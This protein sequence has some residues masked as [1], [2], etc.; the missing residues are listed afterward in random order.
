MRDSM[1][2]AFIHGVRDVRVASVPRP[3][4]GDGELLLAVRAVGI[5]GSDLHYYLEGGIGSAAVE[6]PLILGHEFSAEIVDDRA[7]DF[8]LTSGSLVA[9]E[10]ARAC[11]SCEWCIQG[12]PNLCP[13]VHFAGSP[14]DLHGGLAEYVTALPEAI[15]PVPDAIDAAAAALLEP[16]GVAIH[17][18]DLARPR[19]MDSVT[20]LGAGPIGLLILQVARLAGAARL[21]AIDPIPSRTTLAE[22]LG[23]DRTAST[24]EAVLEW[25]DGRGTDLVFE[26]TNSSLAPDQATRAARIGGKVLLV[27]IPQEETFSFNASI[28][29]RKGLTLKMVRRMKHT[30]PRA[31]QM[32]ATGRIQL[33]PLVTHRFP[34]EQTSA[35]F[36]LQSAC[37][38]GVLKSVIEMNGSS[39]T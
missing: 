33:D 29:R 31:I 8:G 4:P 19:P 32:A 23:A 12:H 5:C 18:V 27:G 35:A 34:L 16:L 1:R 36:A 10:P 30:Y 3:V 21:F 13:T 7:P 26:A 15:I 14:P 2:A 38:D 17:A 22:E 9:V 11:G 25:T 20:V 28:M 39:D 37:Q 24:H 6:E